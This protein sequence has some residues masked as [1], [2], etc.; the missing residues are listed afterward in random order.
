MFDYL[1]DPELRSLIIA[2]LKKRRGFAVE[3]F[4]LLSIEDME[5]GSIR[6]LNQEDPE[7]PLD[8]GEQTVFQHVKTAVEHFLSIRRQRRLGYDYE[9]RDSEKYNS[10]VIIDDS[11]EQ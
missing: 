2:I 5:D 7:K 11:V 3:L 8:Q 1:D 6:I 4:G 9:R 10:Q